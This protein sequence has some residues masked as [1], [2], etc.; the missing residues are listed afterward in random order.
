MHGNVRTTPPQSWSTVSKMRGAMTKGFGIDGKRGAIP[1]DSASGEGNPSM[2]MTMAHFC[3]GLHRRKIHIH[4]EVPTSAR[5]LTPYTMER[6]YLHNAQFWTH[7]NIDDWAGPSLRICLHTIYCLAFVCL[8]RADEV[9]NI[10]VQ[11]LSWEHDRNGIPSLVLVLHFRKTHQFGEIKP[12]IV[13]LFP[14]YLAHLCPVRA[15]SR[16]LKHSGIKTGYLFRKVNR[17]HEPIVLQNS[18]MRRSWGFFRRNL[19]DIDIDTPY[20]FGTHS[21]R[22]G[23][24]QWLSVYMRWP[25]RQICEYGG[26][27]TEFSHLTIV[28][29]LISWA[30]DP[31]LPRSEYFNFARPPAVRCFACNRTCHCA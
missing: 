24:C 25:L 11:D 8:L 27:S 13:R 15:V 19:I 21:F 16:W 12:F 5:S 14:H 28:K 23:G 31:M 17:D 2:S 7:P 6:L 22:R 26:W 4:G 20:S 3:R 1:W 10:Q 29:Y 30:D 9:L 18:R